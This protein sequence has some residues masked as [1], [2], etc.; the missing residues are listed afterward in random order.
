[1]LLIKEKISNINYKKQKQRTY[2]K[3]KKGMMF[4]KLYKVFVVLLITVS[5]ISFV[6]C[7]RN[8]TNASTKGDKISNTTFSDSNDKL[9]LDSSGVPSSTPTHQPPVTKPVLSTTPSLSAKDFKNIMRKIDSRVTKV[10]HITNYEYGKDYYDK[11]ILVYRYFKHVFGKE[12]L[13]GY[14]LYYD[15]QGKLIYAEIAH[16]RDALYNIYFHN[17]EL[18]HVE[19]G[20]FGDGDPYINGDMANVKSVIKKDP[21]Y[22]FVLEDLSLC[23]G[24]AYK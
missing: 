18:L 13:A 2:G 6:A 4:M 3:A 20:P 17:D 14:D 8:S 22:S 11:D 10:K 16:Y 5:F 21:S 12:S 9:V 15:E 19:V 24:H 7:A 23:L 1:M